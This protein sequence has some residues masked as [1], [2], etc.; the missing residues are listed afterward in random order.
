MT[1]VG[2]CLPLQQVKSFGPD[3]SR[4]DLRRQHEVE[5]VKIAKQILNDIKYDSAQSAAILESID[6]H[7]SREHAISFND[8]LVKDADKLWRFSPTG[9]DIDYRRFGKERLAHA[10]WTR[11]QIN[12]WLFTDRAKEIALELVN[13]AISS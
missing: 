12:H 5:G 4:A 1:T 7:D 3:M 2:K 13:L 11:D 8:R 6:G 10:L 9:I